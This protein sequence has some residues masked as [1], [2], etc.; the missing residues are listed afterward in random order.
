MRQPMLRCRR[1]RQGAH[2]VKSA[3]LAGSTAR[4]TSTSPCDRSRSRIARSSGKIGRAHVLNPL[5]PRSPLPPPTTLFRSR[6][7]RE[8]RFVGR[9][10]RPADVHQP[11]RQEPFE[12][13]PLLREDR[14]STRLKSTP[15]EISPPS[16][17]DALPISPTT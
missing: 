8:A 6:P 5:P 4:P 3:S 16:P 1:F 9:V 17:H 7:P 2:H 12:D 15:T 13:R 10:H 11:V 14:K